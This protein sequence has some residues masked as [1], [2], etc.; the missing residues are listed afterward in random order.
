MKGTRN[1]LRVVALI[2]V[3]GLA[4][5]WNCGKDPAQPPWDNPSDPNSGGGQVGGLRA[6][7]FPNVVSKTQPESL[8][9]SI[10]VE[11]RT[12]STGFDHVELRVPGWLKTP[13]LVRVTSAQRID[14]IPG[15]ATPETVKVVV[16]SFVADTLTRQNRIAFDLV[17]GTDPGKAGT[18]VVMIALR[19]APQPS[20]PAS[21][22]DTLSLV[23]SRSTVP[24]NLVAPRRVPFGP[25]VNDLDWDAGDNKIYVLDPDMEASRITQPGTEPPVIYDNDCQSVALTFTSAGAL[26]SILVDAR[27][28]QT[29]MRWLRLP[30]EGGLFRGETRA[31]VNVEV[32]KLFQLDCYGEQQSRYWLL[33][34]K[35]L[36]RI[37]NSTPA[38]TLESGSATIPDWIVTG[39]SARVLSF[40]LNTPESSTGVV[41]N[42][43]RLRMD[44]GSG[45]MSTRDIEAAAMI[46]PGGVRVPGARG[47]APDS[48]TWLFD[49]A[50]ASRES[51][52]ILCA[53]ESYGIQFKLDTFCTRGQR[54]RV[55]LDPEG[56]G[57]VSF[58][59]PS[60]SA[61]CGGTGV[62]GESREVAWEMGAYPDSLP[63]GDDRVV[64]NERGAVVLCGRFTPRYEGI[65]VQ[66]LLFPLTQRAR[67][68]VGDS[69]W[70][71]NT[72]TRVR[73]PA[74]HTSFSPDT[75]KVEIP[76][77]G[78]P[79]AVDVATHFQVMAKIS[80]PEILRDVQWWDMTLAKVTAIGQRSGV[81]NTVPA[82][83]SQRLRISQATID[84]GAPTSQAGEADLVPNERAPSLLAFRLRETSG[85]ES[86]VADSLTFTCVVRGLGI[87]ADSV[88]RSVELYRRDLLLGAGVVRGSTAVIRPGTGKLVIPAGE[89]VELL[90]KADA[91]RGNS[92]TNCEVQWSVAKLGLGLQGQTS[93][94]PSL[95]GGSDQ[96]GKRISITS[97]SFAIGGN[98]VARRRAAPKHTEL[99]LGSMRI[100]ATGAEDIRLDSL[101]VQAGQGSLAFLSSIA[102]VDSAAPAVVLGQLTTGLDRTIARIDLTGLALQRGQRRTLWVRGSLA[103]GV[104]LDSTLQVV[105]VAV[106]GT[107]VTS[108]RPCSTSPG[109]MG[110]VIEIAQGHASV[111][112]DNIGPDGAPGQR[113]EVLRFTVTETTGAES[114][115]LS[116]V[117]IRST[118]PTVVTGVRLEASNGLSWDGAFAGDSCAAALPNYTVAEGGTLSVRVYYNVASAHCG[119]VQAS[120]AIPRGLGIR[121]DLTAADVGLS[122][123]PSLAD[124]TTMRCATLQVEGQAGPTR[125]VGLGEVV[126]VALLT[127][128]EGGLESSLNLQAMRVRVTSGA[129]PRGMWQLFDG[130]SL[131][132]T[133]VTTGNLLTFTLPSPMPLVAPHQLDLSLT[134]DAPDCVS[135]QVVIDS[136]RATGGVSGTI[137][138]FAVPID[139][140]S[141]VACARSATLVGTLVATDWTGFLVRWRIPAPSD[142]KMVDYQVT[143]LDRSGNSRGLL[144]PVRNPWVAPVDSTFV[145]WPADTTVTQAQFDFH[146]L[147]HCGPGIADQTLTTNSSLPVVRPRAG[148]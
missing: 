63:K 140:F 58:Q 108:Q 118:N 8:M 38:V 120:V 112:R 68:A 9:L 86:A 6:E 117:V 74:V 44:A 110:G 19:M 93:E 54:L 25:G 22:A 34:S 146:T 147:E 106:H 72:E 96:T 5:V 141:T 1:V 71:V 97:G 145:P 89:A 113:V 138:P 57:A 77:R 46:L 16:Q 48:V 24:A 26:A 136:V 100:T 59:V 28:L 102:V 70:V 55:Q 126:R 23:V 131:V 148:H 13:D 142:V 67:S 56:V 64:P 85:Q 125:W 121:T 137:A 128:T 104:P 36:V 43:L 49:L 18:Q 33:G 123:G 61:M 75:I 30:K 17:P 105:T 111:R 69:V 7:I 73:W 143:W 90:L 51:R 129:P 82:E 10:R 88:F 132:A 81:R 2:G 103:A 109:P 127:L 134:R 122:A 32:D 87:A 62:I 76:E 20:A 65:Y 35:A 50:R 11:H 91:V 79:V 60:A 53:P 40:T 27:E 45:R 99:L 124:T 107:G 144:P 78:W 42:S 14:S 12:G 52:E 80:S 92:P 94:R 83:L 115:V 37:R 41:L 119:D 95:V 84:L 130:T 139:A 47:A 39:D 4:F 114:L 66:R 101:R 116:R 15:V 29:Q 135:M 31:G 133:A 3:V 21:G 98:A